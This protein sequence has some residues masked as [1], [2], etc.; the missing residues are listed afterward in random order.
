MTATILT[1]A[2]LT[3]TSLAQTSLAQIPN[4]RVDS[5]REAFR[6]S[7]DFTQAFRWVIVTITLI[8]LMLVGIWLQRFIQQRRLMSRPIRIFHTLANELKV[9]LADQWLLVRIANQQSLPTPLT[10]L[11]SPETLRHHANH[12]AQALPPAQRDLTMAR[13]EKLRQKVFGT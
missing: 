6:N 13:V 8:T 12:Y 11:L 4:D 1:L 3:Q 10:L 7:G 2:S 5:V 9:P